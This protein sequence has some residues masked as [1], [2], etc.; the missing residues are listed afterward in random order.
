MNHLYQRIEFIQTISVEFSKNE[1][2]MNYYFMKCARDNI[3]GK[4]NRYGYVRPK[5]TRI[6]SYSAPILKENNCIYD[7]T[8]SCEICDPETDGI[9]TCKIMKLAKIGIRAMISL[10][11]NPIVFYISREHNP[12]IN[13]DDYKEHDEIKV[14]IIGKRFQLNDPYI[15]AI[16]EIM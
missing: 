1:P 12:E 16:A 7:V 10:N 8:Y 15:E 4:C 3:E 5:S 6:V 13:F 9:Y 2:D 14:R 11:N